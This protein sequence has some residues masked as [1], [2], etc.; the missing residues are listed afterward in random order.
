MIK[1][2]SDPKEAQRK[3]KKYL[4]KNTELLLSTRKNKKYMIQSPDNKFIHFGAMGYPDF[5][6]TKD[7]EKQSAYLKRA[8]K[9][10]GNWKANKYS[11]NNLA[12]HIL[13]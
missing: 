7:K 9:I 13:W 3:A 11:P 6:K 12:I 5:T 1:N 4:G 2:F 8:T 10:K